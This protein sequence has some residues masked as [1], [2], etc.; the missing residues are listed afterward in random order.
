MARTSRTGKRCWRQEDFLRPLI[1]KVVQQVMEAEMDN[2][3]STEKGERNE[4]PER[5]IWLLRPEFGHASGQVGVA[6]ATEIA[7]G[8]SGPMVSSAINE[9]RKLSLEISRM[10]QSLEKEQ[11]ANP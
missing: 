2:A 10:N 4:S 8:G 9:A 6:S 11:F 7:N 5:S 1:R 3:L